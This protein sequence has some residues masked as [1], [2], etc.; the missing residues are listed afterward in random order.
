M[1]DIKIVGNDIWRGGERIGWIEGEWIKDRSGTRLGYFD[2]TYVYGADAR[3]IAYVDGNYL[4][5]YDGSAKVSSS[6]VGKEVEGGTR[7]ELEKCAIYILFG[8]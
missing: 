8:D 2:D 7:P 4:N 3:K 5:M 1:A 6:D